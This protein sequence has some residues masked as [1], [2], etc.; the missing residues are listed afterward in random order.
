MAGPAR[1]QAIALTS[2]PPGESERETDLG[3]LTYLRVP[4]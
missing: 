4:G 1:R 3:Q 2:V